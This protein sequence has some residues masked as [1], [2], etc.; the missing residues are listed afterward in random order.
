MA[1]LTLYVDEETRR[2]IEA[3]ARQAHLSVSRWVVTTLSRSLEQTW[4]RDYFD[5]FGSLPADDLEP[6]AQG[7]GGE[8]PHGRKTGG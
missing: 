3:A 8:D 6:P 5:L 1:Q 7:R 4:P 2:K